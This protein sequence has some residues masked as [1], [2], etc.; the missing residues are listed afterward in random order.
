MKKL[1]LLFI[2]VF[3][4]SQISQG[5]SYDDIKRE[6]KKIQKRT[7]EKETAF[8]QKIK[9]KKEFN[10]N[11]TKSIILFDKM[12]NKTEF[13]EFLKDGS[14]TRK[15]TYK[16]NDND[17]II[18]ENYFGNY[19]GT[20]TKIEYLY[21]ENNYMIKKTEYDARM[22]ISQITSRVFGK[23][24]NLEKEIKI[25]WRG[26]TVGIIKYEYDEM[27]RRIKATHFI[28]TAI[29]ENL[30]EYKYDIRN[31]MI[32]CDV[33]DNVGL[34]W[35]YVY[36]Y[37]ERG[38]EIMSYIKTNGSNNY[39]IVRFEYDEY[40]NIISTK[41]YDDKT[42]KNKLTFSDNCKYE[43]D[44]SGN[45]ITKYVISDENIV[46]KERSY[47]YD[48][49]GNKI[50]ETGYHESGA[51][52]FSD[53]YIYNER[54]S[55]ISECSESFLYAINPETDSN[56]VIKNLDFSKCTIYEYEYYE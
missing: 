23:T 49:K 53:F 27:K 9:S 16:Y 15:Y 5:Q 48:V 12:G 45:K 26:D 19:N 22:K 3:V 41:H 37:D 17:K 38:N 25:N 6:E 29:F 46:T 10:E 56:Y 18:E 21:D 43:Y 52:R 8:K 51:I 50:K 7:S 40:N 36:E 42:D 55:L 54:G 47:E 13:T 24:N 32:E 2:A 35:K 4:F 30:Y 33:F 44:E 11:G 34:V 31:N 1:S 14:D 28:N 39:S 20:P